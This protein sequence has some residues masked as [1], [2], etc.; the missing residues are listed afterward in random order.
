MNYCWH[1]R[2]LVPI[3]ISQKYTCTNLS[4]SQYV[5][6]MTPLNTRKIHLCLSTITLY[7]VLLLQGKKQQWYANSFYSSHRPVNK[8]LSYMSLFLTTYQVL[9]NWLSPLY[10][11][12]TTCFL[13][14][15]IS[16]TQKRHSHYHCWS[17][18]LSTSHQTMFVN[19]Q[20]THFPMH[21][22]HSTELFLWLTHLLF[23]LAAV[24][25]PWAQLIL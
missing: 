15:L 11:T 10:H 12:S 20:C 4:A 7:S 25:F 6:E 17:H 24:S 19:V 23:W 5:L 22:S 8:F 18:M 9:F 16:F 3:L 21:A 13:I 14:G 1:Y 2:D